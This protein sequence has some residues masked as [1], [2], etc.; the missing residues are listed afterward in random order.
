V[1]LNPSLSP[2]LVTS[3]MSHCSIYFSVKLLDNLVV[4]NE[5]SSIKTWHLILFDTV[6]VE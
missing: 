4:P 5:G 1:S 3:S 2:P 6:K